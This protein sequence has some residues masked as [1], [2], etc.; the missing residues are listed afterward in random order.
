MLAAFSPLG[1]YAAGGSAMYSGTSL[2]TPQVSGIMA[3]LKAMHPD[4]SPTAIRSAL[5][6]TAWRNAPSGLPLLTN[7]IRCLN[8]VE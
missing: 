6:A 5:V 7:V 2:S 8:T 1:I 4:W 3:L